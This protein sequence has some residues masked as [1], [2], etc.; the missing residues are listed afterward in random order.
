MNTQFA[1]MET[2]L[3]S[4]AVELPVRT[5]SLFLIVYAQRFARVF[6][7]FEQRAGERRSRF[8]DVL[9]RIWQA[10]DTGVVDDSVENDLDHLIPGEYW[11]VGG[12]YDALAQE[13][14][15]LAYGALQGLRDGAVERVPESAV[16][17][18]IRLILSEMRLG[19]TDPGDADPV[20]RAFETNLHNEL[21]VRQELRFR[22]QVLE[23]VSTQGRT[24]H[25]VREFAKSHELD[26][27]LFEPDL[28]EG[29][30]RDA[31]AAKA[32]LS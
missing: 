3:K 30:A 20:G 12:F 8:A 4:E 7:L 22:K 10:A 21:L 24:I 31:A 25:E 2:Q 29:L 26:P 23:F 17:S 1:Q 13:V 19:C 27:D 32:H 9:D 6:Q 18:V 16:L 5:R 15:G 14:G 28:T 11:V